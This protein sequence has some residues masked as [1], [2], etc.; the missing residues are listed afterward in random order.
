MKNIFQSTFI[1]Y[2]IAFINYH[3]LYFAYQIMLKKSPK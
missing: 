2:Q 3:T 1:D